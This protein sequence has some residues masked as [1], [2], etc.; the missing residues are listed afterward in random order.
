MSQKRLHNIMTACAMT[1]AEQESAEL[2][3]NSA[4]G[5]EFGLTKLEYFSGLAMSGLLA[6]PN[7]AYFPKNAAEDAVQFAEA[8][9]AALDKQP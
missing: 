1:D 8:L 5:S 2:K 3:L 6:N 7:G 9:I 4:F